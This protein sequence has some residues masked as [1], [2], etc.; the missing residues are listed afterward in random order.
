MKDPLVSIIIPC[1]NEG[2]NVLNTINSI[3]EKSG[4]TSYEIVVVD[5]ASE[6]GC[7][8]FLREKKKDGVILIETKS[9]HANMARNIGAEKANGDIFVFCDPHILVDDN[10]LKTLIDTLTVPGTGAVSPSIRP[11]EDEMF[12]VG[13]LTWGADL[14]LKWLPSSEGINSVPV[15]PKCC[16]AITRGAFESVEGFEEG[17]RLYGYDDV[18]FTLKLWLFD[19]GAVINSAVKVCHI[20]NGSRPYTVS[21]NDIHY[22]LLRMAILHFNQERLSRVI[23]KIKNYQYFNDI[24]TEVMLSDAPERRCSIIERRVKDDDWYFQ[25]FNIPL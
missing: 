21:N 13:G 14:S 20:F 4:D 11:P 12:S 6:D 8:D 23:A 7:C 5:D 22:N 1:Q 16:L 24:F 25:K 3:R 19:L 10:W 2:E 18:E 17:F 9:N 15:L